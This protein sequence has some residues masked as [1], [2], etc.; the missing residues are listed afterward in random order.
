MKPTRADGVVTLEGLKEDF[1]KRHRKDGKR[2]REAWRGLVARR[3][4][5][6]EDTGTGE[7]IPRSRWPRP[8]R[9][10]PNLYLVPELPHRFRVLYTVIR[11]PREG[12]LV[13]IE[14]VGDHREYDEL[15]GY[16]TS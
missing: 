3:A 9:D 1:F 5:L 13:R 8:F 10:L 6:M 12:V 7:P 11:H 16:R 2:A 4:R 14:W 15:F